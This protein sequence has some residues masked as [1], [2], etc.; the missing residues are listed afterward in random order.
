MR[1]QLLD[2]GLHGYQATVRAE[3]R[4]PASSEPSAR[5]PIGRRARQ[6]AR[7]P[8]LGCSAPLRCSIDG[9]TELCS[10]KGRRTSS[11]VGFFVCLFFTLHTEERQRNNYKLDHVV[12]VW[13]RF[14]WRV[15]P[16]PPRSSAGFPPCARR[17]QAGR[18]M[19][20][21]R[22]KGKKAPGGI[23]THGRASATQRRVRVRPGGEPVLLLR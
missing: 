11:V 22:F 3:P 18:T 6:S 17:W 5:F 20:L 16:P 2:D 15:P 14:C 21:R 10:G 9:R 4:G 1:V 19:L 8:R 23:T 7:P 12:S 13:C